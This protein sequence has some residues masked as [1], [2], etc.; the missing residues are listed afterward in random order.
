[1]MD[2]F[3]VFK[4]GGPRLGFQGLLD[5]G[6]SGYGLKYGSY[7]LDSDFSRIDWIVILD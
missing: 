6:S 4:D 1:M 5:D 2:Y 3:L 7:G